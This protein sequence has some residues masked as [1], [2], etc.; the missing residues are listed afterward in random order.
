M[1]GGFKID[2]ANHAVDSIS[3]LFSKCKLDESL[4]NNSETEDIIPEEKSDVGDVKSE[5]EDIIPVENPDVG[6]VKSEA[7]K[8][9]ARAVPEEKPDV[10]GI[11]SEAT[12]LAARAVPEN[13]SESKENQ[14]NSEPGDI[15]PVK[16]PDNGD[17]ENA[18]NRS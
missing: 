14:N 4:I 3:Q 5:A 10:D 7:T 6:G 11:N 18:K 1:D 12:K 15:I 9:A 13:I 2:E 17:T 16:N 8:L